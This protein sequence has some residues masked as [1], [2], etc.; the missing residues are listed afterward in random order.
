MAKGRTQVMR[1]GISKCFQFLISGFK[2]IGPF[3]DS[4]FKFCVEFAN[5]LLS[6][7]AL[8]DVI[9]SLQNSDGVARVVKL[10]RPSARRHKLHAVSPRVCEL[11]LPAARA[12][13]LLINF[14][15]R[16]GENRFHELVR[17][18]ADGLFPLPSVPFLGAAIPVCDD[19]IHITDENGVM[20]EVE[21]ARLLASFRRRLEF[22]AGLP[23][24]LLDA[25]PNGGESGNKQ[26]K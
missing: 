15:K 12:E 6:S 13:Q 14:F 21:Q 24:L 9:I 25:A 19:I 17:D 5:F 20:C 26:R 10:Q 2:L 8:G 3:N 22:V 1:Y 16:F 18:I 4:L 11:S 23:K 7:L